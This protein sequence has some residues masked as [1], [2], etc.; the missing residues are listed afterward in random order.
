MTGSW[1]KN[2][3]GGVLRASSHLGFVEVDP[4]DGKLKT[5]EDTV[6]GIINTLDHFRISGYNFN[7]NQYDN[8]KDWGNP[9][10][11]IY[12]EGLRYLAGKGVATNDAD[13]TDGPDVL[14]KNNKNWQSPINE[15]NWCSKC[16]IIAISSGANSYDTDGLGEHGLVNTD[17]TDMNAVTE[18]NKVG[19]EEGL[20]GDYLI[21]STISDIVQCTGKTVSSLAE[22]QGICPE[23]PSLKG[24]Y[25]I[26]GLAYYART[27]DFFPKSKESA[28]PTRPDEVYFS[29][30]QSINT[31]SVALS[32]N[33]PR[34]EIPVD[35]GK[36][37]IL[38]ACEAYDT[39][40]SN[41]WSPC[42]MTDLRVESIHYDGKKLDS[43][44]LMI[45]WEDATSGSDY[46]M[47]GI[48]RLEFCVGPAKCGDDSVSSGKVRITTSVL[49]TDSPKK[50]RFGYTISGS[51]HDIDTDTGVH[52]IKLPVS[53]PEN[54]NCVAVDPNPPEYG[55]KGSIAKLLE[56]PLWYAAKYG[57]FETIDTTK[58]ETPALQSWDEDDNEI[59]DAFFKATNPALLESALDK[60]LNKVAAN[61]ASSASVAA[62]STRLDTTAALYQAKFSP[63]TWNGQL[64]AYQIETNDG[65][66]ASEYAWDAGK[67]M[68]NQGSRLIV[69]YNDD[70]TNSITKDTKG[71]G[72]DFVY[73]NLSDA[74]KG[75]IT[76]D[77]LNYIKGDQSK[78]LPK[79]PLRQRTGDNR[80]LGDIVNS[81]PEFIS[82]ISQFYEV[83]PG[84]AG[85]DYLTYITSSRIY[86]T[87]P[88]AG[89]GG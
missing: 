35:G 26:A 73:G 8:D 21:S 25:H 66:I 81:D 79:G 40:E 12:L 53:C 82:S 6:G 33:A 16:S 11:E 68:S 80:L 23:A 24:G 9:L 14:K 65:S 49:Q 63:A 58:A 46:D 75:L 84:D 76:E 37:S 89:S 72:I 54:N 22:V 30:V 83:L 52:N 2:Q 27:N 39:S 17:E 87:G 18:T 43:G 48:E 74:Q 85:K 38:P 41:K 61:L 77:Q 44:S 56:N 64:L 42:S 86:E 59:P 62:N 4:N 3:S 20:S 1:G 51:D 67:E 29:G 45:V 7:D 5:P 60:I 32:E 31:Y 88:D 69:S 34:F 28:N 15:Q 55:G 19:T 10:S 71:I 50:M 13:D 78:E 57:G 36:I 70:S 47:D